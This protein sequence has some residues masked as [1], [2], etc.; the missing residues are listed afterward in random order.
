MMLFKALLSLAIV[1]TA[2]SDCV[3]HNNGTL[4]PGIATGDLKTPIDYSKTW[5]QEAACPEFFGV[6]SCC[7]D[8]SNSAALDNFQKLSTAFGN[9]GAGCDLCAANIRRFFCYFACDPNQS[10]YMTFN[11]YE[12]IEIWNSTSNQLQNISVLNVSMGYNANQACELF[13][14]CSKISFLTEISAGG[15][16]LGFFTFLFDR[17]LEDS[18]IKVLVSMANQGGLQFTTP[19]HKCNES[20]PNG[21]DDLGYP[22]PGTCPCNFCTDSCEPLEYVEYGALTDGFKSGSVIL[23]YVF[24]LVLTIGVVFYKTFTKQRRNDRSVQ[25]RLV[26]N[27]TSGDD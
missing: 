7:T 8:A 5:T 10:E 14:S 6:P 19:V 23:G 18:S 3:I 11:D 21:F 25:G 22:V 16:A 2:L 4:P 20:Y 12:E 27:E 26:H 1:T 24:A 13:G 17:G 9:A 15:S